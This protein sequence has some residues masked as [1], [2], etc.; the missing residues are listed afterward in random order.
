MRIIRRLVY[1][2]SYCCLST[3]HLEVL[4]A[5]LFL[6]LLP[7][8]EGLDV[9]LVIGTDPVPDGRKGTSPKE[10]GIV[11]GLGVIQEPGG[12]PV[13]V[14]P[15]L[16]RVV[17]GGKGEIFFPVGN[18]KVFQLRIGLPGELFTAV[19]LS[20]LL[21]RGGLLGSGAVD[22]LFLLAFLSD[23]GGRPNRSLELG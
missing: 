5:F 11:E 4:K 3:I 12:Q 20:L 23:R 19:A 2:V 16:D 15:L 10:G 1:I 21:L 8:L 14:V 7:S 18:Q 6:T 17:L 13:V 9:A 22:R